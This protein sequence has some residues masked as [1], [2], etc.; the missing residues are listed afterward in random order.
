[1]ETNIVINGDCQKILPTF[2]EKSIDLVI[3]SPPYAEKRKKAY[4]GIPANQYKDWLLTVSIE[5]MRVLKDEGSFIL[6]I[7]EGCTKGVRDTYVLEYLLEMSKKYLWID[8]FIWYKTN[9][10]PTGA[11]NRLKDAWEYCFHFSKT[12]KYK[13]YPNSVSKSSNSKWTN[14]NRKNK[15]AFSTKNGSGMNMSHRI[16]SNLVRPSNVLHGSKSCTN[17][18]HPAVFPPY[19]PSFFI[20]LLSKPGDIILDPFAGSG[21]TLHVAKQCERKYIGIEVSVPYVTLIEKILGE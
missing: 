13:F 2:P 16:I 6:N 3:T 12:K 14:E 19:I 11:K 20:N 9:P 18:S 5:I 15:G 7:K 17:V 4:G 8:T 10:F 1:M 21:T